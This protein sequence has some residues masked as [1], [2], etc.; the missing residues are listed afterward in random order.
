MAETTITP[1]V[2]APNTASD[3]IADADATVPTDAA[4]GWS[5]VN[6]DESD[7]MLVKFVADGSSRTVTVKAGDK[8]PAE[9]SGLGDLSIS[10]SANDVKYVWL[11]SAR[12]MRG[13]ANAGTINVTTSNAAVKCGAFI[14]PK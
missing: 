1:T 7:N 8:P 10:L 3:D 2:I 14:L 12:F 4:D 9:R 6:A 5:I 13:G 11:E